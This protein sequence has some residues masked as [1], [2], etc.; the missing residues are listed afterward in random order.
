MMKLIVICDSLGATQH[1]SF[2]RPL[3]K[4][5]SEGKINLEAFSCKSPSDALQVERIITESK[6]DIVI[7]SRCTFNE[8]PSLVETSRSIG[9]AVVAHLDDDLLAVPMELGQSKYEHYNAPERLA[10]IRGTLENA[11]IIYAST[12]ALANRLR[13]HGVKTPILAGEIYCASAQ[14]L[15]GPSLPSRSPV[16]GYM[17]TGGHGADLELAL[18]AIENLMHAIPDLRF[19]S[20]G[21]LQPP[22]RLEVFGARAAHFPGVSDYQMFLKRL[23]AL[24]WWIGIAPLTD[25]AFNRCK[26]DTKWVEYAT[27]GVPVVASDLPV[28]ASACR[29]GAGIVARSTSDWQNALARLLADGEERQRTARHAKYRLERYYALPILTSQLLTIL[30]HA[31]LHRRHPDPRNAK[32]AS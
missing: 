22:A 1:I 29:D 23:N 10:S 3:Q 16:I 17:A 18:P 24:G 14:D 12:Q 27:C 28:Y 13:R 7:M 2:S 15:V 9:A 8:A 5:I 19:E 21:T 4:E 31:A 25:T 11:D 30:N 26:A 32:R 20:F 6:P